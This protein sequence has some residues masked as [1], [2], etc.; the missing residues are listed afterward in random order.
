MSN[1]QKVNLGTPPAAIDGDT[2]R[3]ANTKMNANVD[4]L[5]TQAALTS[6]AATITAAQALT[7]AH[8]GKR[9]TFNLAAAGVI[10]LPSA[11][12]C[13]AD[14]VILLR[15]I[16]TATATLAIA[17]GSGD[18]VAL[19]RLGP[20]E[21][22]MLDTNG[23]HAWNVLMR[24]RTTANDDS[25][26]GN[27]AVGGA[28]TV[29]GAVSAGG[30]LNGVNSPNLLF[31]GSGEFGGA[32]WA[33]S[34]FSVASG[35]F[36]EGKYFG[37][38]ATI[39]SGASNQSDP[40]PLSAGAGY[41]VSAEI[42][43]LGITSGSA[44]VQLQF[45]NSSGVSLGYSSAATV[46]NGGSWKYASIA[47]TAPANS[48]S[49]AALIGVTGGAVAVS[50]GGLL[51]R[52]IKVEAGTQPSLYSQEAS[53][54]AAVLLLGAQTIAGQKNFTSRPRYNGASLL[55]AGDIDLTGYMPKAGGAF[56]GNIEVK[57][58]TSPSV[59]LSES[60]AN[61]NGKWQFIVAQS[62]AYVQKNTN[63][64]GDWS[65]AA[66]AVSID[67]GLN[68]TLGGGLTTNGTIHSGG[69]RVICASSMYAGGGIAVGDEATIMYNGGSANISF[70]TGISGSNRFFSLDMNGN[71]QAMNGSWI[72]GSDVRIK[73]KIQ[74][75]PGAL[76][77]VLAMRGVTYYRVNEDAES[78]L[79]QFEAGVIA[80]ELRAVAPGLVHEIGPSP[81]RS[82]EPLLGVAYGNISAY[83]IEA[84]K[85]LHGQLQVA[86]DRIAVLEASGT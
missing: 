49:A 80:Q 71:G 22:A 64:A 68:V 32:G 6:A 58:T 72:N 36:G 67:N 57:A 70:R 55:V 39:S 12:A 50:P 35:A 40:F 27:L 3:V 24:G 53:I 9:V 66:T 60:T 45:F 86:L 74:T 76:Q 73:A 21:T 79:G 23:V 41:V 11:A 54:A 77:K 69:S 38:S 85:E 52:R 56:T 20:G 63:I 81:D 17:A 78:S 5:S 1:L 28:L 34:T 26:P 37:N 8:V 10:N 2:V 75:I 16:G 62:G 43:A 83:L 47:G 7:T 51:F 30:K 4:V 84:M 14:S 13:E 19:S 59:R 44:V 29:A 15:N 82:P 18:T 33:G 46:P 65:T 42:S 31:N 61:A 25:V 48:V